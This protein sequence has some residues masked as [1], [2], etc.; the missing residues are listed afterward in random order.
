MNLINRDAL[1]EDL[2]KDSMYEY[3]KQYRVDETI[4][5]QKPVDAVPVIRCKD[6]E[7]YESETENTVSWCPLTGRKG[8]REDDYCSRAERRTDE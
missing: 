5:A 8:L 1:I 3:I 6:C 2:K 4:Q 7:W